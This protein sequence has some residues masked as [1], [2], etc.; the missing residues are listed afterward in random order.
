MLC[1][2]MGNGAAKAS[3]GPKDISVTTLIRAELSN[4]KVA[5]KLSA[6]EDQ[7]ARILAEMAERAAAAEAKE[8]ARAEYMAGSRIVVRE[9]KGRSRVWVPHPTEVDKNGKPKLMPVPCFGLSIH[10]A[11]VGPDGAEIASAVRQWSW[12]RSGEPRAEE[13]RDIGQLGG[14]GALAELALI[15]PGC[16][17]VLIAAL[18]A[19]VSK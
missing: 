17:A 8:R 4:R 14:K 19:A 9:V 12:G 15:F 7:R 1:H 16:R 18:S 5:A 2:V 13:I 10:W 3:E 6:Y 11:R